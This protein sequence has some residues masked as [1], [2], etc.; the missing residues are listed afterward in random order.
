[1]SDASNTRVR[2][3]LLLRL[4]GETQHAPSWHGG[5]AG[6]YRLTNDDGHACYV[7]PAP[8]PPPDSQ[9]VLSRMQL[10]FYA[11]GRTPHGTPRLM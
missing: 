2:P 3:L 5:D 9:A 7:Y 8:P 10:I 11:I 4:V 6:V 1:M